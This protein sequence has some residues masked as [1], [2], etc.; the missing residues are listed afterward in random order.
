MGEEEEA[1]VREMREER[2]RRVAA[3]IVA[4]SKWE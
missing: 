1:R 2:A 4:S 3:A